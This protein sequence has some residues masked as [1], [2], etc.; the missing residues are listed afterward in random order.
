[1]A[2]RGSEYLASQ[3][4]SIGIR[5]QEMTFNARRGDPFGAACRIWTRTKCSLD[6]EN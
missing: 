1:M 3:Y 4:R 6:R 5:N 2:C